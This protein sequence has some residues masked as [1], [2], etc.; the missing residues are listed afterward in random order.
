M[1]FHLGSSVFLGTYKFG[2]G[3][4]IDLGLGCIAHGE[5]PWP[6]ELA[7][8]PPQEYSPRIGHVAPEE[9]SSTAIPTHLKSEI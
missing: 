9:T 6:T 5:W 7:R 2:F 8:V 3:V 4:C 1:D